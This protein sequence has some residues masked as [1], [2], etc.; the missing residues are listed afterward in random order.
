MA[1]MDAFANSS[2]FF[3]LS[4]TKDPVYK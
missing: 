2:A 3:A 1:S 4:M